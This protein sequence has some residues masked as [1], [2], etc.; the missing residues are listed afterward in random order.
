M[1][2]GTPP[3]NRPALGAPHGAAHLRDGRPQTIRF[4]RNSRELLTFLDEE[5]RLVS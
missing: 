3:G 5:K 4:A 1:A 2:M